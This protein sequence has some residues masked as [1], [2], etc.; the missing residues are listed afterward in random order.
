MVLR[1][2]RSS[3]DGRI[4][5]IER[6][7]VQMMADDRHSFDVAMSALLAGADADVVGPDLRETDRR[8]NETE[9]RVRRQLVVHAS[10]HGSIDV[11]VV[12]IYMSVV[13]DVERIGDYA[14][15]IFDIAAE[16]ADLSGG[17]DH[18]ELL[19]YRDRISRL[20]TEAGDVFERR[21]AEVARALIAEGDA[22]L[23]EFDA[24]VADLINSELPA[25]D[26]VPR[27]LLHR[28]LKR[29]VAHCMNVLSAVVM[30]VDRI[31]YFDEDVEDRSSRDD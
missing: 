5:R 25:R 2:L 11:P 17:P 22:M 26:A 13:K 16:G 19:G 15:N 4:E 6:A 21:D 31:D 18:A 14:K 3:G 7:I 23:D 27:A 9:K 8:V 30:P 20:I 1:F 29:I 28:H 24:K 12:L 10:V